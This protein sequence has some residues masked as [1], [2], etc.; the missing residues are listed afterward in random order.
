MCITLCLASQKI[1]KKSSWAIHNLQLPLNQTNENSAFFTNIFLQIPQVQVARF[2]RLGWCLFKKKQTRKLQK[3]TVSTT[4][5][6][7]ITIRW[8][9]HTHIYI[10]I[11][12]VCFSSCWMSLNVQHGELLINK[13]S[14]VTGPN[15]NTLGWWDILLTNGVFSQLARTKQLPKNTQKVTELGAKSWG[16][17]V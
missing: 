10:Y 2:G 6:T 8:I 9:R 13:T 12:Y 16:L 1:T 17:L 7:H 5:H 11:L 4:P 14:D 15:F 3:P